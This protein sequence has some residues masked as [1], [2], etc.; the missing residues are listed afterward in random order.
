MVALAGSHFTGDEA[1][2][3]QDLVLRAEVI[4]YR[5]GRWLMPHGEPIMA[6]SPGGRTAIVRIGQ[7]ANPER[8]A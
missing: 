8:M 2:I 5:L 3:V 1:F 7:I 6:P 4:R